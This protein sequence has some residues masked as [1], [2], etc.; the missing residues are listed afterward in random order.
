MCSGASP[1]LHIGGLGHRPGREHALEEV[2]AIRVVAH[3]GQRQYLQGS[4]DVLQSFLEIIDN[5]FKGSF[6][7]CV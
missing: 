5:L 3:L 6:L 4:L 7:P 2:L 1:S